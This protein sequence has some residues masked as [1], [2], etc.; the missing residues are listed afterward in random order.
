VATNKGPFD[1]LP[2]YPSLRRHVPVWEDFS[3]FWCFLHK[4]D[5]T[6]A[7]EASR[8]GVEDNYYKAPDYGIAPIFAKINQGTLKYNV[9]SFCTHK[10]ASLDRFGLPSKFVSI[11]PCSTD[12]RITVRDFKDCDWEATL[13]FLESSS[14]QGV[15][16]NVGEDNVPESPSLI[17]LANQ[18]NI[19]EAVEI[20]KRSV[21]YIGIDSSLSVIAAKAL[22]PANIVIKSHNM[23]LFHNKCIYYSPVKHFDFIAEPVER[24]KDPKCFCSLSSLREIT[25]TTVQGL[26]DIFWV[27]QKLAPYF[28]RISLNI[29]IT[30]DS[31]IQKR[32]EDWVTLFPKVNDV[33]FQ[34]TSAQEYDRIA[35]SKFSLNA[36][37]EQ[38]ENGTKICNYAV[39]ADLES[40]TRIDEIDERIVEMDVPV[41]CEEDFRPRFDEYIVLYI[42]GAAKQLNPDQLGAWT[43]SYWVELVDRLFQHYKKKMPVVVI[44]ANFDAASIKE[45]RRRLSERNIE[46]EAFTQAPPARVLS[47]IKSAKAFVGFQSGLNIMADNYDVK[48]IMVY[49]NI[50]QNM[51]Y[52][53]CKKRNIKKAFNAFTFSNSIEDVVNAL[54]EDFL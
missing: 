46:N 25:V 4:G 26:G 21:G 23:H 1:A 11:C 3:S 52:T 45:A 34:L 28:D 29:L 13:R 18:T 47:I 32:S 16:L 50:L 48:Q 53:W 24:L 51:L 49:Y 12:K 37:L 2:N 40:G 30:E 43:V 31:D 9:S 6:Q 15:V 19:T 36:I 33:S 7:L 44:G 27:Y 42:S 5:C 22:P 17:N 20:V 8:K 14:M 38:W 10:L 35:K 54:P 39:N 41:L